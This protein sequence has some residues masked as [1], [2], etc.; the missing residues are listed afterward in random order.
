MKKLSFWNRVLLLYSAVFAANYFHWW[1]RQELLPSG[2][3]KSLINLFRGSIWIFVISGIVPTIWWGLRKFKYSKSFAPMI[4]WVILNIF[5]FGTAIAG[6]YIVYLSC[7]V[8]NPA[9]YAQNERVEIGRYSFIPPT[10][11][12]W[13]ESKR[14]KLPVKFFNPE[15]GMAKTF[16]REIWTYETVRIRPD[17]RISRPISGTHTLL[18]DSGSFDFSLDHLELEIPCLERDSSNCR[19]ARQEYT[20]QIHISRV[21]PYNNI[22]FP[23]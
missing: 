17:K 4:T 2:D 6:S 14:L 16:G 7:C 23:Y 20:M 21:R 22:V 15:N 8:K 5:L 3:E 11:W 1:W 12:F 13:M 19:H 18:I 9:T 10:R